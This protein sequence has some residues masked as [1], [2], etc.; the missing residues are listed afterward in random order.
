MIRSRPTLLT[1]LL[2]SVI[3]LVSLW[4]G[5]AA[6]EERNVTIGVYQNKPGVFMEEDGTVRGFYIDLIEYVARKEKWSI[7]YVPGTWSDV[8]EQMENG[9]TDLLVAIAFTEKRNKKYDYTQNTVFSNW[10]QLYVRE[11]GLDSILTLQGRVVA[12]VHKDIYTLQ[13]KKLL[14]KFNI[15]HR[16]IELSGYQEVLHHIAKGKADAGIISRTNGL[17]I[18]Q[19]FDVRKSLM[20]CCPMEIRYAT[21]KGTNDQLIEA[22]DRHLE[23]LKKD[24]NSLYYMSLDQWF[25]EKKHI[26]NKFKTVIPFIVAT[27]VL[28][29]SGSIFLK[30]QVELRT[31][32]LVQA[33][34]EAEAANQAKSEFLANMSHEIR[35]PMNAIIGLNNLALK[36][37]LTPKVRDYLRKMRTASNSLLR[38]INDILDFSK[39]EAGKLDMENVPFYLTEVFENLGNFFRNKI[40]DKNIEFV[41]ALP[42][43]LSFEVI[44]DPFRLEQIFINLISN[45]VKF[46]HEGG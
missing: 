33:N 18:E 1:Y 27:L 44:G 41:L 11:S 14:N 26:W 45:A 19:D 10:G 7:Q 36:N 43:S 8:L 23:I 6:S 2:F 17:V 13:F 34:K 32:E 21:R 31:R 46:T 20:V 37:D 28:L 12:G 39:I 4:T 25:S 35:T 5:R 42:P 24:T 38:I 22:L 15:R 9:T 30:L 29:I 40:A 16:F 3:I